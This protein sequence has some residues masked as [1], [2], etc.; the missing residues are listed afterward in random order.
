MQNLRSFW[1]QLDTPAR[2]PRG[3]D[4]G[5]HWDYWTLSYRRRLLRDIRS[6][7]WVLAILLVVILLPHHSFTLIE[8]LVPG[9]IFVIAIASTLSNYRMWKAFEQKRRGNG[10]PLLRLTPNS[11]GRPSGLNDDVKWI[12]GSDR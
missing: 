1:S 5:R 2:N 3:V 8:F 9:F 7:P 11:D 12:C 4:L 10:P 6:I